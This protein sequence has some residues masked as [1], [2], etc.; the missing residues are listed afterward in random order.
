MTPYIILG[1]VLLIVLIL[2]ITAIKSRNTFVV[3]RNRVR[4]QAAQIDVQL[5]RR[6]DLIPN[7]LATVKGHAGFE[8]DTLEAVMQA[9]A[10]VMSAKGIAE[11]ARASDALSASLNRL[12]AVAEGYPDLKASESFLKLEGELSET[13]NKIAY[14]RQFYNDTVLKYNNAIQMFPAS[15]IA[16]MCGFKEEEYL[17]IADSERQNVQINANDFRF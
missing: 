11:T 3:V 10:G 16:G 4:D 9:R 13:E 7:L 8:R 14:A 15:I 1:I 5:K 12:F 17:S 6:S 2:L